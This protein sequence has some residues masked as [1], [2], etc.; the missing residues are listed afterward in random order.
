M[1]GAGE[2]S[3]EPTPRHRHQGGHGE[4]HEGE[5]GKIDSH[6]CPS[7]PVEGDDEGRRDNEEGDGHRNE[8]KVVHRNPEVVPDSALRSAPA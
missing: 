1:S 5:L 2:N 4:Q 7:E 8:Y 3:V 6:G